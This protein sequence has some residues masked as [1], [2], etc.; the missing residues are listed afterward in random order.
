[1]PMRYGKSEGKHTIDPTARRK[2]S[3]TLK[4]AAPGAPF[5]WTSDG[6]PYIGTQYAVRVR[7]SRMDFASISTR[8]GAPQFFWK[9]LSG[10]S[11]KVA[12]SALETHGQVDKL[13]AN[14]NLSVS[15]G[16]VLDAA[17]LRMVTATFE[18]LLGKGVLAMFAAPGASDASALQVEHTA[19]V[20]AASSTASSTP[21]EPTKATAGEEASLMVGVKRKARMAIVDEFRKAPRSVD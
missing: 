21:G 13:L 1:M 6:E 8:S 20:A 17:A 12:L 19:A 3:Q 2:P 15:I 7:G 16:E 11:S 10:I 4:K 18:R 5:G 14:E 9:S